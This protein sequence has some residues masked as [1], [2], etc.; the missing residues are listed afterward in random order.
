MYKQNIVRD[1]NI[2]FSRWCRKGYAIFCSIKRCVTI[3]VLPEEIAD[4]SVAKSKKNILQ[5]VISKLLMLDAYPPGDNIDED[6]DQIAMQV[7]ALETSKC[8]ESECVEYNCIKYRSGCRNTR[9]TTLTIIFTKIISIPQC[10]LCS[11]AELYINI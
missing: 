4:C 10:R 1:S 8:I 2:R 5:V 7:G 3:A 6:I 11:G 9:D